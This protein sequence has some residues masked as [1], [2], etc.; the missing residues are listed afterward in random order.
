M[1]AQFDTLAYAKALHSAGVPMKQAEA[2]ATAARDHIMPELATRADIVEI[3]HMIETESWKTRFWLGA[4]VV[5]TGLAA[6][7]VLSAVIKLIP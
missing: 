7:G 4:T 1:A 6:I 5:A 2:H 3:K